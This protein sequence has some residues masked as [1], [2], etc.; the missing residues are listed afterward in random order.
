KFSLFYLLKRYRLHLKGNVRKVIILGD[1]AKTSQLEN[2]FNTRQEYGYQLQKVFDIRD[3]NETKLEKILY[4]VQQYG[5]EEIYIFIAEA[6]NDTIN[7]LI[8]YTD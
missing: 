4:Y 2:F 1:N 5:I 6:D 3:I 8:Q 7:K